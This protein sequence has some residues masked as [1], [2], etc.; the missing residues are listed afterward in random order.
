VVGDFASLK[1]AVSDPVTEWFPSPLDG[2]FAPDTGRVLRDRSWLHRLRDLIS[3]ARALVTVVF[4]LMHLCY[5]ASVNRFAQRTFTKSLRR[6]ATPCIGCT[7]I[8]E[9]QRVAG[10]STVKLLDLGLAGE[11]GLR[12]RD[13]WPTI[14]QFADALRDL[15]RA[16]DSHRSGAAD[17]C[18]TRI[19]SRIPCSLPLWHDAGM[20][21]R[22]GS[23][24]Q[25]SITLKGRPLV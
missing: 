11:P 25:A 2:F 10:R 18:I 3:D 4:R 9:I 24:S 21:T 20:A 12:A 14:L 1:P 6:Y 23:A 5:A 8:R 13:W 22:I 15:E 19:E 7:L 17:W 16:L